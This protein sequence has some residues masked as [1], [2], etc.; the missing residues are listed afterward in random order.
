LVEV[1]AEEL[2]DDPLEDEPEGTTVFSVLV[3]V[4]VR[5]IGS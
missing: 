2:D 1:E 3:S 4:E 5:T